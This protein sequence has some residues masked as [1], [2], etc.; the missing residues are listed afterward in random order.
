MIPKVFE[1]EGKTL[2]SEDLLQ[3]NELDQAIYYEA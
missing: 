3:E 1:N 2:R